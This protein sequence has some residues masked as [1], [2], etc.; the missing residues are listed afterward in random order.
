MVFYATNAFATSV[1]NGRKPVKLRHFGQVCA[2]IVAELQPE[3]GKPPLVDIITLRNDFSGLASHL[4][5][6]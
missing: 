5:A 3:L 2:H 1:Q 6:V 4:K